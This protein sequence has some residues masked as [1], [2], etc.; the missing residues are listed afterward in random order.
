MLFRI[1]FKVHHYCFFYN[2]INSYQLVVVLNLFFGFS[3]SIAV[4]HRKHFLIESLCF[5]FDL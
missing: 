5:S 3:T 4:V 2:K 1:L